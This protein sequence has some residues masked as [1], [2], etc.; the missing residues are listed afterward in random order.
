[1]CLSAPNAV[2]ETTSQV[3]GVNEGNGLV[4]VGARVAPELAAELARLADAGHRNLSQEIRWAIEQHVER[5]VSRSDMGATRPHNPRFERGVP[6]E[7]AVDASAL[8][9]QERRDG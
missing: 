2:A 5:A 6:G 9:G 3:N 4:V 7:R 1:L 8:A